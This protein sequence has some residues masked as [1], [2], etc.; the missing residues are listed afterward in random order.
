MNL[1]YRIIYWPV[2][3]VMGLWHPVVH[4]SGRENIPAGGALICGNHS[5]YSDPLWAIFAMHEK[6]PFKIM[7]KAS[8][9]K[10]PLLGW[11][12]KA[13]G[14]FGVHRGE[15]DIGAIKTSMKI[16]SSG[17][18]MLMYP[19]GTR[20]PRG[21]RKPGKT[22]AVMLAARCGV[23]LLPLFVTNDKKPFRP[24]HLVIGEPITPEYAGRRPT[25]E[26]LRRETDRLM[27]TI[28]RLGGQ[29]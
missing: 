4:I 26:E 13:Y 28:Y 12:L 29:A 10:I 14:V 5:S 2:R 17:E 24:L 6:K 16:L 7:A 23:P 9:L 21:Q 25:S 3:I 18:K 27:D 22:G 1:F 20:C 15:N 19:E 8:L 11:F